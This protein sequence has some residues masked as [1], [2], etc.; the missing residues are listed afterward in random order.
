MLHTKFEIL[1]LYVK[2]IRTLRKTPWAAKVIFFFFTI[3]ERKKELIYI[4]IHYKTM[5]II[6]HGSDYGRFHHSPFIHFIKKVKG[7]KMNQMIRK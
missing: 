6:F 2:L 1:L 5:I 7:I 4:Y 3:L